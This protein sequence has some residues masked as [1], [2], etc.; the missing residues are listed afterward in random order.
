M[1]IQAIANLQVNILR[2]RLQMMNLNL[3]I[4][5]EALSAL[6]VA[7]YDPIYGARPLK[8]AVQQ[9]L[10]NP[11]AQEIL[12]G[13]FVSGDMIVVNWKNGKMDFSKE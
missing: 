8:R 10:E 2:Q 1:H 7:G 3:S 12:A 4:S 11:L 9:M 6:G 5:E 13:N